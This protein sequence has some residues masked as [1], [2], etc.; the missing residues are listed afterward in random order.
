MAK[1]SN[2]RDRELRKRLEA[3]SYMFDAVRECYALLKSIIK[4]L[5]LGEDE[6]R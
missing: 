4:Y 2:R 1:D 6:T 3:D 5:V